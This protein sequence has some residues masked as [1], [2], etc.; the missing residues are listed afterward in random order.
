VAGALIGQLLVSTG[1]PRWQL[2]LPTTTAIAVAGV[3]FFFL[4]TPAQQRAASPTSSIPGPLPHERGSASRS[5]LFSPP[6][7]PTF[8]CHRLLAIGVIPFV[9]D[10]VS[11]LASQYRHRTVVLFSLYVVLGNSVLELL[12]NYDLSL[13]YALEPT[14]NYNGIVL[15]MGWLLSA[16][17]AL[18]TSNARVV[19]FVSLHPL[20]V[21]SA[22]PALSSLLVWSSTWTDSVVVACV[23]FV[24]FY[25][26]MSFLMVVSSVL[27]ASSMSFTAFAFLFSVNTFGSLA[28]Q[29]AV[30]LVI[31]EHGFSLS[32]Q[33]K[34]RVFGT[35]LL[36]LSALYALLAVKRHMQSTI[37]REARQAYR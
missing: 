29:S 22:L 25:A 36:G 26:V 34:Y 9:S 24:C 2:F 6:S 37:E 35:Q 12:L 27:I 33:D 30:Q 28:V 8:S 18:L 19:T 23:L 32:I 7:T 5:S 3:A 10:L 15:A 4:P 17:A 21:L 31:G 13:W 11:H 1:Y 14:F 16:A 20:L